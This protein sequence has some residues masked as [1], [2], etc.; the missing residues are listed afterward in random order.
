MITIRQIIESFSLGMLTILFGCG[1]VFAVWLLTF[2]ITFAVYHILEGYGHTSWYTAMTID[3]A[4]LFIALALGTVLKYLE[5][6]IDHK[7]SITYNKKQK[8][9]TKLKS[10]LEKLK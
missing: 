6:Y 2:G 1:V 10:Q 5:Y 7:D 8:K 9:I 3:A 4:I